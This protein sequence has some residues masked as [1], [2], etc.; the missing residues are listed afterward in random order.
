MGITFKEFQR[1]AEQVDV[2]PEK[3][4]RPWEYA[5]TG[6]L[7]ES[8]KFSKILEAK[9]PEGKLTTEQREMAIESGWKLLWCLAV[10]CQFAGISLE[11]VAGRGFTELDRIGDD[12]LPGGK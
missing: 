3:G 10:A 4:E 2:H 9:L 11:E 12:F 8:G 6:L 5:L 1:K 7:S